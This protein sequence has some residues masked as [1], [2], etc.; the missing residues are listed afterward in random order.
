MHLIGSFQKVER[1]L[2]INVLL[3]CSSCLIFLAWAGLYEESPEG[4]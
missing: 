3:Q 1:R 2:P 4:P